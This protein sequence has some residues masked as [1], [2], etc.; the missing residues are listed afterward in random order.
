MGLNLYQGELNHLGM[1]D[2]PRRSTIAY[3]NA[4]RS[5]EVFEDIFYAFLM[6]SLPACKASRHGKPEKQ[7]NLKGGVFAIDSTTIDLCLSLYDC[8]LFRAT[9]GAV[10]L[11]LM[12]G[13]DVYLSVWAHVTEAKAMTRRLLRGSIRCSALSGARTLS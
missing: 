5:Y 10:K 12:L 9:K 8:P 7:L 1:A 6:A 4:N 11:H 2:G 3:N 13:H